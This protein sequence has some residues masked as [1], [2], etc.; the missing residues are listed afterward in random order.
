[1]EIVLAYI[2]IGFV[3]GNVNFLT[4]VVDLLLFARYV[5]YRCSITDSKQ[6][7]RVNHYM[8]VS[9]FFLYFPRKPVS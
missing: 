2:Y 9:R 3:I 5:E 6:N 8:K 4:Y 7:W 1:M